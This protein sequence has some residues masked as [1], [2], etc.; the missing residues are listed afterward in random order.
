[1]YRFNYYFL[2]FVVFPSSRVSL[3]VHLPSIHQSLL[4]LLISL[5]NAL[6]A[7]DF[8]L[9]FVFSNCSVGKTYEKVCEMCHI[10]LNKIAI[11]GDNGAIIPGG[12]RIGECF[13]FFF[14]QKPQVFMM[15]LH[16]FLLL[17]LISCF[18]F[19]FLM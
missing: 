7:L 3:S 15:M 13:S 9:N 8:N 5:V 12:V 19:C 6:C 16:N 18:L 2:F 11:F 4:K 1:M 17:F 10:T 14:Y